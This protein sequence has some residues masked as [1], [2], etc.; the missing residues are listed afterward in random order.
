MFVRAGSRLPNI[1]ESQPE[2]GTSGTRAAGS[3]DAVYC[4][5][6][7]GR[8]TQKIASSELARIFEAE[9]FA[10]LPGDRYN[11]AP[12]D[13]VAAVLVRDGRRVLANL[14][15]GLVPHWAGSLKDGARM[16][17][18]RA[19]TIDRSP[20]FRDA[21]E[22]KRCLI[23]ADGFY[24]WQRSPDGRRLPF[25]ITRSDGLPFAFAGL[26]A[27]WHSPDDTHAA[28]VRTCSIVTTTPNELVARLH[29][30]MPV[31]LPSEAWAAWLDPATDPGELRALLAPA[32]DRDLTSYPVSP[33]VNDPRNDG[34]DLVRPIDL[35]A[36]VPLL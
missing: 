14:R 3:A 7:C 22:R 18:A 21:F 35:P 31:I 11:V 16:I 8:F 15:W 27:T 19:E 34:P 24:E 17:N 26:R 5:R 2:S 13:P 6:M 30:R 12:T 28:P 29:N 32:P 1:A 25:Y 20:A 36:S 10:D 9:D 23:P 33:L 4:R